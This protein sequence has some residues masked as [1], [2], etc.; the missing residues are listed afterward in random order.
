MLVVTRLSCRE[1]IEVLLMAGWSARIVS[2]HLAAPPPTSYRE[3]GYVAVARR[4]APAPASA[5]GYEKVEGAR[6][7]VPVCSSSSLAL[8]TTGDV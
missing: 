3:R 5:A 8:P 7:P 1:Q 4:A 6:R 2:Q